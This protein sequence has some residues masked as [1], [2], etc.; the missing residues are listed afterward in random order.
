MDFVDN[1]DFV[2][3]LVRRKLILSLRSRTSSTL[4]FEA[5]SISIKSRK[6]PWLTER[7]CSQRSQGRA[8]RSAFQAV[9]GF[10]QQPG[11]GR[12]TRAARP[13]KQEG[14]RDTSRSDSVPQRLDNMLLADNLLPT[15]GTPFTVEAWVIYS[16]FRTYLRV[17]VSNTIRFTAGRHPIEGAADDRQVPA[18]CS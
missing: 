10:G 4:V 14:M 5:A 17:V 13:G 2:P 16:F 1:I 12:L 7:Q 11:G 6:R 8:D 9:N 18:G 3:P 15:L